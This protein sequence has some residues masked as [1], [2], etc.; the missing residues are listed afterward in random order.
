[1]IRVVTDSV[2]DLPP[3]LA[4]AEGIEV[5]PLYVT[6]GGRTYRDGVDLTPK[7]FFSQLRTTDRLPTTAQPTPGDFARTFER[8]AGKGA[9]GIVVLTLSSELSG[10]FQSAVQAA[11]QWTERVV[12]VIDTRTG[13][14][15]QGFAAL[16]A[17]RAARAAA[18]LDEVLA[19]ARRVLNRARILAAIPTLEYL[20]RGGRIGKAAAWAGTLLQMKPVV[21]VDDGVVVPVTR[22]R[23]WRRALEFVAERVVE[24]LRTG[25]GHLAVMHGDALEEGRSLLATVVERVQPKEAILAGLSPVL[26]TYGGPGAVAVAYY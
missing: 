8:L 6:L 3:D 5:V 21:T 22:Q 1:M 19:E 23:T 20:R 4:Q 25:E 24:E 10:T 17:A 18:S 11:R 26:G 15:A 13:I 16:A 9:T 7:A 14:M 2:A 12:E